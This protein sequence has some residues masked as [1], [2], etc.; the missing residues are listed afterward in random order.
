MAR[1]MS[2]WVVV[3]CTAELSEPEDGVHLARFVSDSGLVF[4]VRDIRDG[5]GSWPPQWFHEVEDGDRVRVSYILERG[6]LK[7]EPSPDQNRASRAGGG[8]A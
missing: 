7:V 3:D 2:T 4:E 1:N 8:S 5:G 6:Q